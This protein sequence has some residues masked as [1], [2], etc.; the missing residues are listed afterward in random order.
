MGSGFDSP[1]NNTNNS[2]LF[3]EARVCELIRNDFTTR[4]SRSPPCTRER[5]RLPAIDTTANR[6]DTGVNGGSK[7][8]GPWG[9]A[10]QSKE[11]TQ[12][13][14]KFPRICKRW[15]PTPTNTHFFRRTDGENKNRLPSN[16][17]KDI[18]T[19]RS[20]ST[21]GPTPN[22]IL[23]PINFADT[24]QAA[25]EKRLHTKTKRL[26]DEIQTTNQGS[27]FPSVTYQDTLHMNNE[28]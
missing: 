20:N 26:K 14:I 28:R 10:K 8:H 22:P 9:D 15:S 5:T 12:E 19:T 17:H 3:N 6:R 21:T 23:L 18:H 4:H 2:V 16:L 25:G 11:Q 1:D 27:V 7:S 13:T 24:T